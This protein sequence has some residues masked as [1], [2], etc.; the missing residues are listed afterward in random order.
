MY[1]N[2]HLDFDLPHPLSQFEEALLNSPAFAD[3]NG[4]LDK[5]G[6]LRAEYRG[7]RIDYRP[8][9]YRGRVRGSLHTFSQGS[10]YGV[11]AAAE[12]TEACAALAASLRLPP[13]VLVV[14]RLEAGVNLA[15]PT[16]PKA[17]LGTLVHHKGQPFWA[18]KPPRGVT[19]PLEL[20]ALHSAYNLKYYDKGAYA[21]QQG[22]PL[23]MGYRHMLRFEVVFTR[24]RNLQQLT[25]REE[26]TLADLPAPDVLVSVAGHLHKQWG[27]TTRRIPMDYAGLPFNHAALLK[28]GVGPEWWEEVRP[29]IPKSTFVRNRAVFRQLL[30]Q[31]EQRAGP[32]PYDLL[33]PEHLEALSPDDTRE[34][35]RPKSGTVCHSCNQL[36]LD[37]QGGEFAEG[38]LIEANEGSRHSLAA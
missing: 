16:S 25:G 33:L 6:R 7:L 31:A 10:N 18:I 20:V 24:A 21:F 23:P 15:V 1:D 5:H 13:E 8:G 19:R 36:D 35:E 9:Q 38:G 32:H 27:L 26:V 14:R 34:A 17:F 29:G 12:V 2:L 4:V 3:C 22:I 11:F 28:A 30:K 37:V